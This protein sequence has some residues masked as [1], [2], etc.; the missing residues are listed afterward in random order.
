MTR[1]AILLFLAGCATPPVEYVPFEVKVPIPV[2][3]AAQIPAPPASFAAALTRAN[4]LDDKVKAIL[5]DLQSK[6][7]YIEQL[8]AAVR[9]CQ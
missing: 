6:D 2:P 8:K 9:G 1:L 3:C 7:G 5:A 4:T